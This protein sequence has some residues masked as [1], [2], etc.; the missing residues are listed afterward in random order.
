MTNPQTADFTIT[1]TPASP[2]QPG[3]LTTLGAAG[4]S[5]INQNAGNAFG[6]F[7]EGVANSLVSMFSSNVGIPA[8][9]TTSP[10]RSRRRRRDDRGASRE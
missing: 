3:I 2:L 6:A 1:D 10:G 4:I 8:L 7:G 5:G 9:Q